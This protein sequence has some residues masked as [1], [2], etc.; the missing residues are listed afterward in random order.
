MGKMEVYLFKLKFNTPYGLRVGGPKESIDTLTALRMEGYYVIPWSSWKGIF[1]RATEILFASENHFKEHREEKVDNQ[2]VEELLKARGFT[3]KEVM[4]AKNLESDELQRFI[5][6]LNCP[7]ERLYG[8][9]YFASAVTFSDTLIDAGINLR[10][11]AVI[12]RVTGGVRE[13]HL[14]KEEI[15]DVKSV[16]VKVIVRDGIKEWLETLKFLSQVGTFIGGGKSR[17]IGYAALDL[18][19]SEYAKIDSLTGRPKFQPL[20]DI[21]KG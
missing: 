21:I 7:I 5:A 9:E 13:Q 8:S 10:T 6:M 12:D 14:F 3:S 16:S 1:R 15:V 11:H 20:S 18:K 4:K 19:E 2:K 17:G